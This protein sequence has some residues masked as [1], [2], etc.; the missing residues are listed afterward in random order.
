MSCNILS[1]EENAARRP[2]VAQYIRAPITADH[3]G[4]GRDRGAAA[5]IEFESNI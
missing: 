2:A 4:F 1:F 5:Q 3:D